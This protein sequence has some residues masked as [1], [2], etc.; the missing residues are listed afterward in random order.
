MK[1]THWPAILIAYGLG[2]LG[3]IQV[4]RVAPAAEVL[5]ADMDLDLTTLGWAVSLITLV[6]AI[7]GLFAGYG[8]A[9]FGASRVLAF[10]TAILAASVLLATFSFSVP[11]LLA[12]RVL[13]GIGYLGVVV[14][15][16]TL[17]A[18]EASP[19]DTPV[20]LALWGTF[21]TLGL[22]VAAI[23][24][25]WLSQ[26]LGWREWYGVNGGLLAVAAVL[27]YWLL[28]K[29]PM[30]KYVPTGILTQM[31]LPAASWLLGAAFFGV[32][33]LTLSLL[34]MLPPFL[35]EVRGFSPSMAGGT[36][37]I[38][39]LASIA[40]SFA[41]GALAPRIGQSRV[42]LAAVA[43]LVLAAFPGFSVRLPSPFGL[44]FVSLAVFGSGVLVAHV[45]ASV[46]RL[47]TDPEKIGPANGLIA[48]IGSVGALSGPPVVGY[49]VL[50][51][52]WMALSALIVLFSVI[53]WF[54]M[55]TAERTAKTVRIWWG[56]W[57]CQRGLA[58]TRST[59]TRRQWRIWRA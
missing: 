57:L 38:V 52:G 10:G 28:P 49:L 45:F 25:G 35:I 27:A 20:A 50:G 40:G 37:G 41:Y 4:G 48:Q 39:A 54:T 16:P 23:S 46:P 17:I 15:A 33:L 56:G 5:R 13:E 59:P 36:T 30:P 14:A 8:V 22:S 47:V 31:R 24:G 44:A 7:C 51:N 32:T 42:V 18:R 6:S 1:Q 34:S 19:K 53:F 3:A 43:F 11:V 9:R 21:F 58:S 26:L 55:A 29:S 12:V 2:V